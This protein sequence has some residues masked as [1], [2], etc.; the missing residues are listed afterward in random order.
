MKWV[1]ATTGEMVN[2]AMFG[3]ARVVTKQ[4]GLRQV[5]YSV[6]VTSNSYHHDSYTLFET[7]FAKDD[8]DSKDQA[9]AF[10]RELTS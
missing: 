4:K 1:Q 5:S 6:V 10:L 9:E 8:T 7:P 3:T 2:L